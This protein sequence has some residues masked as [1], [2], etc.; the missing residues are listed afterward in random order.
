MF[1]GGASGPASRGSGLTGLARQRCGS[2]R[3]HAGAG[4]A[5]AGCRAVG[6]AAVFGLGESGSVPRVLGVDGARRPEERI[7]PVTRRGWRRGRG[8]SALGSAAVFIGGASGPASRG[9]GLT[10]LARQRSGSHR[11]HAGAGGAAAGCRAVGSAAVFRLRESGSAPRVMGVDGDRRTEERIAPVTRRGWRCGNGVSG[12]GIRCCVQGT[13]R[14]RPALGSAAAFG[15]GALDAEWCG[16]R[17][18]GPRWRTEERIGLATRRGRRRRTG[19]LGRGVRC[20]VQGDGAGVSGVGSAVVS[21]DTGRRCRPWAPRLCS[22]G[23]RGDGDV[24][25]ARFSPGGR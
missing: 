5:A 2:H 8:V 14:G 10:G 24:G 25:G 20:C 6:S 21:R 7:A 13:G 3:G 16:S 17:N 19:V 12:R 4:G 9:S 22:G 11:G 1:I 15:S 18:V 23:G